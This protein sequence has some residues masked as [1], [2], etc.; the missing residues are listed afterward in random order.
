MEALIKGMD[1]TLPIYE[2]SLLKP[3]AIPKKTRREILEKC[4]RDD[5]VLFVG[6][7]PHLSSFISLLLTGGSHALIKVKKGTLC[8]VTWDATSED[9]LG[10]LNWVMRNRHL[11]AMV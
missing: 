1:E 11:R 7:E 2:T 9:A 6:H 3:E 5:R 10:E 4:G 8:K